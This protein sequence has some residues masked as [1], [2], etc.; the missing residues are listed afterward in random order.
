MKTHWGL[1]KIHV[2]VATWDLMVV[3]C[4]LAPKL[5]GRSLSAGAKPPS[6]ARSPR[7][8]QVIALGGANQW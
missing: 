2:A 5:F 3:R 4:I 6:T 8:A 1:L 7:S